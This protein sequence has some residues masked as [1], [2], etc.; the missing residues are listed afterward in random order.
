MRIFLLLSSLLTIT[1]VMTELNDSFVHPGLLHT[2]NDLQRM[3]FMVA[4]QR[5]PWYTAFLSF[6]ADMHSLPS[7]SI[8]GPDAVVTRD[9]SGSVTNA[10]NQH[11][12]D[13]SVAALQLALM[14]SITGNASYGALATRILEA[15]AD[16]LI[17]INGKCLFFF[18]GFRKEIVHTGSDAQ[19]AAA[20]SGTQLVNAAEIIRY[21]YSGWTP[22]SILKFEKM[23]LNIFYPP[24]SQTT[25]SPEQQYP[26]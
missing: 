26:L 22:A 17:I 19:L 9:R 10:G 2:L 16:T 1:V 18:I 21:T 3:K 23:I 20:L 25:P 12:A 6:A 4:A 11:L 8:E 14:Y 15:W 5:E 24:A 7:Y 13:D